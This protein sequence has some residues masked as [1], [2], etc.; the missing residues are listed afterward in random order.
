MYQQINPLQLI[1]TLF[2]ILKFY[3]S[4]IVCYTPERKKWLLL[5]D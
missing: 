2:A 1:L 3:I 4:K 5:L